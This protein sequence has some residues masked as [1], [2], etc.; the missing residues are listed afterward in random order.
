MFGSIINSF[1]GADL[2]Q[3]LSV[4]VDLAEA[5]VRLG[6][7]YPVSGKDFRIRIE[8]AEVAVGEDDLPDIGFFF[9]SPVGYLIGSLDPDLFP[10]G[11]L[12][13]DTGVFVRSG[14]AG[15]DPLAVCADVYG[16]D[17][18][19]TCD[20]RGFGDGKERGVLGAG[21]EVRAALGDMILFGMSGGEAHE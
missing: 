14:I 19:G 21:I 8:V 13:S 15:V 5:D 1:P 10:F 3:G 18:S 11:G 16:D 6:V 9:A 20:G 17:V 7:V 4:E 2:P 12:V